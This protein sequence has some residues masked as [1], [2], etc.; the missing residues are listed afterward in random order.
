MDDLFIFELK[1]DFVLSR[2]KRFYSPI[3]KFPSVRRDIAIVVDDSIEV[4]E[5]E[6]SVRSVLGAVLVS[7]TVFDLY[8]GKGITESRKSVG[9][10][11]TLQSQKETLK[12]E[13]IN[14]FAAKV[15]QT[16]ERQFNATLR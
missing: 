2:E 16:L 12:E 13:E 6:S 1:T 7:L 4:A 15:L 9:L 3:S 5:I 8:K 14:R 11:L 10:G